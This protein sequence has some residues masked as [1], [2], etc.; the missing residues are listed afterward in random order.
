MYV[1]VWGEGK[2]FKCLIKELLGSKQCY[3]IA[4]FSWINLS[5]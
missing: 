1:F 4:K 5:R 3:A 2:G